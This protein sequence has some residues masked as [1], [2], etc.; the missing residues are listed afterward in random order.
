M[1]SCLQIILHCSSAGLGTDKYD[2]KGAM[3][4]K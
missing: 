2:K 1:G 3:A 4:F